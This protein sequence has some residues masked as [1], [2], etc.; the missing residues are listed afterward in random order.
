MKIIYFVKILQRHVLLL[1]LVPL[2][3]A[4]V[5]FFLT[6]KDQWSYISETTIYTGVTSGYTVQQQAYTDV[7]VKN[8]IYDNL[9]NLIRSRQTLEEV[10]A[11]LLAQHLLLDHYDERY[12]SKEH[13]DELIAKVPPD[14]M[15]IVRKAKRSNPKFRPGNHT[16]LSSQGKRCSLLHVTTV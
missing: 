2:L 1:I 4:A 10:S 13:Y 8:T 16:M 9:I 11:S 14:V 7:M 15:D 12:I 5:V 3:L 6:R